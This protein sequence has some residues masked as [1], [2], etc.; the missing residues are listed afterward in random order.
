[1]IDSPTLEPTPEIS[2]TPEIPS[3]KIQTV[4]LPN[5][6]IYKGR[7]TKSGKKVG[8]GTLKT[9]TQ[10]IQGT[11]VDDLLHGSRKIRSLGFE[12]G[13][14]TQNNGQP[15]EIFVNYNM[16]KVENSEELKME[17][18]MM[19]FREEA[20]MLMMEYEI[21]GI[22]G[23]NMDDPIVGENIDGD[24]QPDAKSQK[25]QSNQKDEN[26]MRGNGGEILKNGKETEGDS[27]VN[28]K[29]LKGLEDVN[30]KAMKKMESTKDLKGDESIEDEE[31]LRKFAEKIGAC[32]KTETGS[33]THKSKLNNYSEPSEHLECSKEESA[34][35]KLDS[36]EKNLKNSRN[37]SEEADSSLSA[38]FLNFRFEKS[39]Q[40]DL[41][42]KAKGQ[43][44]L[45]SRRAKNKLMKQ[46]LR[47]RGR[48]SSLEER[49]KFESFNGSKLSLERTKDD[50]RRSIDCLLQGNLDNFAKNEK[51]GQN[52]NVCEISME[53]MGENGSRKD[54]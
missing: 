50:L 23:K 41:K 53:K 29:N 8:F 5:G 14:N 36:L 54:N 11:F 27:E 38:S 21:G 3:L 46:K 16:G 10:I 52:V 47:E 40:K 22:E 24:L 32:S 49:K 31:E 2:K 34:A 45:Q 25:S 18:E 26:G 44:T 7:L 51:C 48:S 30:V 17:F 37:N 9:K 6:D 39:F 4:N 1:M 15:E 13:Q 12:F 20:D 19:K 33:E 35:K 42:S 28:L 43:S